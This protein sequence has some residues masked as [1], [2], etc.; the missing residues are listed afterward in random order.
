MKSHDFRAVL[1][2]QPFCPFW[3]TSVN[4]ENH[5]VGAPEDAWLAPDGDDVAV[6]GPSGVVLVGIEW[7]TRIAF[8]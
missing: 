1:H 6:F 2:A 3:F 4:R 7:I 8:R 5:A